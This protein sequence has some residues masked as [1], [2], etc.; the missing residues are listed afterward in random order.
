[1]KA[2]GLSKDLV[3]YCARHD[4]GASVMRQTGDLKL[5]LNVM[6]HNDICTAVRYQHPGTETVR[7]V[8]NA[9]NSAARFTAQ[10][11]NGQTDN[12]VSY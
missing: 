12:L 6:G 7:N 3:L 10:V 1:M 9:R 5:V 2:A 4:F 8:I 11:E